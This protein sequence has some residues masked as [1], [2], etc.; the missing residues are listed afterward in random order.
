MTLKEK[1]KKI[2]PGVVTGGADN[3]P[4]GIITYTSAGAQFGFSTL[5]ILLLATPMMIAVQEMAARIATV[6]KK[7]LSKIIKQR[8][9]K[10]VAVPI[11]SSLAIANLLT[12]GADT[13]AVAAVISILT[14]I[15]WYLITIGLMA[16][17]WYMILFGKYKQ[18]K[19]VLVALTFMLVVYAISA[20]YISPDIKVVLSGFIPKFMPSFAFV[21]V[22]VGILGTT[23]S[24]Y[25][26]FWQAS[27]E[28]E[29]RKKVIQIKEIG[30]DT[31]VGMIW[32]NVI[33]IFVIIAAASTLYVHHIPLS[34][35]LVAS[36]PLKPIAGEFA[37][38]LFS[39]GII[40]SGL[41]AIPVLAGST[42]YAVSELFGW[43][44]GLTKRVYSAKGFYFVFT[45]SLIVGGLLLTLPINPVDFLFYTQVLD[46]FLIPLVVATLLTIANDRTIMHKH[47]NTKLQNIIIMIF[48][49]MTVVFD[50][51][52]VQ[53]LI[54]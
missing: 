43:R 1:V 11:V 19:T 13:A 4:A 34:N 42:A 39:I 49:A 12:L 29:E 52:L 22:L 41:L 50:I 16:L 28:I 47:A 26:L 46:G 18:I 40:V 54:P 3:D 31:T 27:E 37:F 10:K 51:V 33:A 21:S 36:L 7:G 30:W 6:T 14:G 24:P 23:I 8:Y 35:V 15:S 2:G 9:G 45:I 53:G 38:L 48:L 32:S 25:M 44:E 20:F 17:I 5:W